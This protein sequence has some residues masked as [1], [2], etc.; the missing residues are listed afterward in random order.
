MLAYQFKTAF[1]VCF[2]L[3]LFQGCSQTSHNHAIN[4]AY[5]P[6]S[7]NSAEFV[8]A[9]KTSTIAVYPSIIRTLEETFYSVD[10][11]RQ[12]VS[13][14]NEKQVT[15]AVAK[16]G[17]ID[18]GPM[19]GPPQWDIFMHDMHS[20]A[21]SLKSNTP[22]TQ[23]SIVM[24]FIF[25]P[26]NQSVWG[27]HCFVFD[28]QGNNAFS[29]L[30][31]SHHKLFND[32]N[33]SGQDASE[34]SRAKLV[35]K[36]TQVGVTALI[37]QVHAT[38]QEDVLKNL[39]YS[40]TSQKVT[41]FDQKVDKIFVIA[42]IQK[43]LEHIFMH[44]LKH[45][46]KSGFESNGV[47]SIVKLMPRDSDDFAKFDGE[48]EEFSPDAVMNIDLDPLYR[49]RRDGY[50]AV[51]GTDFKASVIN[52]AS[53]EMAWQATGKVNYIKMFGSRY[54][55]HEG[56]RKEFAWHTTAAIVR[57]FVL[58]VNGH[59]SAPIYTI[60]EDRQLYKQRTD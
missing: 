9:L 39:G 3:L 51:V 42:R 18:P 29:F 43:R 55:A 6:H 21:D 26:G 12:V 2:T 60:T 50:Q 17:S 32:A 52:K 20:I 23:Y 33:L 5:R 1:A 41:T 54:T 11:Q 49:K 47:K 16:T 19:K 28:Q 24:E 22:D 35:E 27:V 44:S 34:A 48:L 58:D 15:T 45:S 7:E 13:L 46:L 8:E 53:E 10:S 31:N 30:L 40:I 25:P 57:R 37:Q 56:I 36:A 59:K 14:L 4:P 38:V